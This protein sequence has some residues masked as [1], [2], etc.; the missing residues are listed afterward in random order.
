MAA[1]VPTSLFAFLAF[2]ATLYVALDTAF[3]WTITIGGIT[4]SPASL[5]SLPSVPLRVS[6]ARVLVRAR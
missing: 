5:R 6:R 1:L 2:A 3:G 4:G